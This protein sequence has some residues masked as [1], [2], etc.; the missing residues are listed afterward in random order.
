MAYAVC[1]VSLR[2]VVAQISNIVINLNI[3]VMAYKTPF[4]RSDKSLRH[5]L[6]NHNWEAAPQ[7][8]RK[9]TPNIRFKD[10]HFALNFMYLPVFSVYKSI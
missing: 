9:I 10:K 8:Q 4:W 7:S 1:L 5:K 2:A 6:V 3:I